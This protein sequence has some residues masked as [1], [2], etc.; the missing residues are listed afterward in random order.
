MKRKL[1]LTAGILIFSSFFFAC[2]KKAEDKTE[3][4]KKGSVSQTTTADDSKDKK[5]TVADI[6]KG[7]ERTMMVLQKGSKTLAVCYILPDKTREFSGIASVTLPE[8]EYL[9]GDM[10]TVTLDGLVKESY[11][12]QVTAVTAEKIKGRSKTLKIPMDVGV[13][14]HAVLPEALLVDV[15]TPAEFREGHLPGA[16]NIPLQDFR[17]KA[18]P[19]GAREKA[20]F[21][22]CR[23]GARSSEAAKRLEGMGFVCRIDLGGINGYKGQIVK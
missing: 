5:S 7:E 22:Y 12:C 10:Y 15:R 13:A 20:V 16:I 6:K 3:D 19:E 18:F 8:G 23:S 21:V 17:E 1:L 4:Q 9:P 14:M 11:P 2:G